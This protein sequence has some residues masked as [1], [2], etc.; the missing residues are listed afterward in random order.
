MKHVDPE[1]LSRDQLIEYVYNLEARLEETGAVAKVQSTANLQ[2]LF[3]LTQSE[4]R[5][6]AALSDG[7]THSKE[8]LLSAMYFERADDAP[9]IKIVDV[10]VCKIRR[11]LVGYPIQIDTIWGTG[12][13]VVD[14]A[15]L[16][17]AMAGETVAP[18]GG[19]RAPPFH[20]P[21]G[22]KARRPYGSVKNTVLERL[23]A[24]AKDGVA[25]IASRDITKELGSASGSDVIKQLANT[26]YIEIVG[27][28]SKHRRGEPWELRLLPKAYEA[29]A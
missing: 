4:A 11:K 21:A 25:S 29:T 24:I 22:A 15:P 13:R 18:V 5:L 1:K 27:G 20:K 12:H 14:T 7:R 23:V 19:D 2:Y 16:K 26:G 17:A 10:F 3:G 28:A 6:L 8:S 9:E